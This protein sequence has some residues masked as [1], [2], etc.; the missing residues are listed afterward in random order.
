MARRY[1]R[2]PRGE[3]LRLAVP[4]GHWKTTTLI[5]GM[6]SS[7]VVAPCVIDS[8]VNRVIFVAWTEQ[9]LV[10]ELCP[11]DIVV[12]DNLSSHKGLNVQAMIKAAGARLLYLPPYSP[13]LNPIET[14]SPRSRRCSEKR[15]RG[16]LIL[17]GPPS[18]ASSTTSRRQSAR[19][20]SPPQD[21]IQTGGI[22]L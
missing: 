1:G 21:T 17:C 2:C 15:P 12:M 18:G 6:R 16:P 22:R 4:H 11:G 14:C 9:A 5:A 13:D 7:G 19:T 3:R 10:P 8:P 20:C